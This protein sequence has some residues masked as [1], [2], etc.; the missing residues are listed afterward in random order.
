MTA[1][2]LKLGATCLQADQSYCTA[3]H[4]YV[5]AGSPDIATLFEHDEVAAQKGVNYLLV[6]PHYGTPDTVSP[7]TTSILNRDLGTACTLIDRGAKKEVHFKDFI[8]SYLSRSERAKEQS[9]KENKEQYLRVSEYS[10]SQSFR[11]VN[12]SPLDDSRRWP[13]TYL[14]FRL[15][16]LGH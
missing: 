9:S 12:S 3:F 7:L 5:A 15:L 16:L 13:R 4:A 8:A 6:Q 10:P 1:L 2:L 11:N 14:T